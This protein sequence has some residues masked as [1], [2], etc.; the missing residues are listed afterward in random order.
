MPEDALFSLPAVRG[1]APSDSSYSQITSE[2]I[3]QIRIAFDN[4]G[5]LRQDERKQLVNGIAIRGV[6]SLSELYA[7]EARRVLR[8]IG[9]YPRSAPSREGL[10]IWDL[11]AE[12]TWI[13]RL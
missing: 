6:A 5:I 1:D 3:H 11:R 2:Q 10:S 7:H 13:D 9:E 8:R 4:A 12:E